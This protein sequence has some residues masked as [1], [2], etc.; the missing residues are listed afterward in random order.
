MWYNG[1]IWDCR[2]FDEKEESGEEEW[3]H[4]E[5]R[6]EGKGGRDG[7]GG[8][9]GDGRRGGGGGTKNTKNCWKPFL[10]IVRLCG[11]CLVFEIVVVIEC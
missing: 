5:E 7:L 8:D 9:R 6:G 2:D 1:T 4:E 10:L 3:S 11:D